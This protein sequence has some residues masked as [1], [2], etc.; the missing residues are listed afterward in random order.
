MRGISF[1]EEVA[2]V[3]LLDA[4]TFRIMATV[5][6]VFDTDDLDLAQAIFDDVWASL[7][8]SIRSSSREREFKERLAQHV[9][10]SIK[11]G[12][13]SSSRRLKARVMEMDLYF[14]PT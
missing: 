12:E 7:P 13:D 6:N 1:R 8:A 2:H 11:S 4:R 10:A 5:H 9:L 3:P 14:W